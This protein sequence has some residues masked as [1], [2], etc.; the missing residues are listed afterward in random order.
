MMALVSC[1][2][3]S[4]AREGSAGEGEDYEMSDWKAGREIIEVKS[5]GAG[6]EGFKGSFRDPRVYVLKR[7]KKRLVVVVVVVE[8]F[9]LRHCPFFQCPSSFQG[10]RRSKEYLA[11]STP[12]KE[13]G[14]K[15][16][17]PC[18]TWPRNGKRFDHCLGPRC[19]EGRVPGDHGR[20]AALRCTAEAARTAPA[21]HSPPPPPPPCAARHPP[22]HHLSPSPPHAT[23]RA[24]PPTGHTHA[25]HDPLLWWADS[26]PLPPP[27]PAREAPLECR[28]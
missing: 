5:R 13:G 14:A 28:R 10:V 18:L 27:A 11:V 23:A 15:N 1:T 25:A 4:G 20:P 12:L 16:G 26:G 7:E 21:P 8:V 22:T 6:M 2:T 9:F 3:T 17:R 19:G 24:A